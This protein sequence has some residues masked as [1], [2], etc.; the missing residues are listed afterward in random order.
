MSE[1]ARTKTIDLAI[2]IA[3]DTD[4]VW[5]AISDGDELT[6]WFAPEARIEPGIGGSVWLSW[7]EGMEGTGSIEVWEEGQRLRWSE[8]APDA[9]DD[10]RLFVEFTIE[11]RSGS[12]ALRLVHSGFEATDDWAEGVTAFAEKRKPV[13]H[14]R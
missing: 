7:G 11:G 14:G 1:G 9:P 8:A 5:R 6:Q 10:R 3:A 4:A 13:F 2:E 12:T